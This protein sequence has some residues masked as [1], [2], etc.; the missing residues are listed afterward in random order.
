MTPS[1]LPVL[2]TARLGSSRLAAKHLRPMRGDRTAIASLI[3]RLKR[4]PQPLV[5]CVPATAEDQPLCEIA[6]A[7]GISVFSGDRDN[8]LL[9]YAQALESLSVPASVIIDADDAFVSVE[10]V[11]GIAAAYDGHDVITCSGLPY[12]G[13]PYLLSETFIR[14]MLVAATTPHGWSRYL[15]DLPGK[16][17]ELPDWAVD[18]EASGYRL[19]L[20]YEEDL[21]FLR[22]LYSRVGLGSATGLSDVVTYITAH[23][24]ELTEMFPSQFDGALAARAR[25]HLG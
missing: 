25:T 24:D 6:V 5:L 8:V 15:A 12:G 10:A 23:R 1:T 17:L 7:E 3:D 11:A 2:I 20:D 19:S 13:A 9:R 18:T 22:H 16:K 14:R 21:L 4:Q